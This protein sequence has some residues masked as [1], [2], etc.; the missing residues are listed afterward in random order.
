MDKVGIRQCRWK[1][2]RFSLINGTQFIGTFTCVSLLRFK[3]CLDNADI[4]FL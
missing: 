1:K 2:K 3:N 4:A